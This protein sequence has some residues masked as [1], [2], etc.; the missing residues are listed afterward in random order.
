MYSPDCICVF[1][2]SNMKWNIKLEVKEKKDAVT[3]E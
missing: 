1:H 2:V 3:E